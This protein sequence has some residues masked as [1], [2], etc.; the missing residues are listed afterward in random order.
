M[1][2]S[3][4]SSLSQ[5][6]GYGY[7]SMHDETERLAEIS[8]GLLIENSLLPAKS[9]EGAPRE[10]PPKKYLA[11][12]GDPDTRLLLDGSICLDKSCVPSFETCSDCDHFQVDSIYQEPLEDYISILSERSQN[13]QKRAGNPETIEYIE[14]QIR[15][16]TKMLGK[17]KDCPSTERKVS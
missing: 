3:N 1:R 6:L 13:L 12:K 4:H 16:Y 2:E 11:L 15:V 9:G 5:T 17:I 7:A 8:V 14:H 10:L